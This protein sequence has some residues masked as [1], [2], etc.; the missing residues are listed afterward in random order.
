ML[1]KETIQD[2]KE[3]VSVELTLLNIKRKNYKLKHRTIV[4][5]RRMPIIV[6][7]N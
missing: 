5:V 1:P 3:M 6:Y 2:V 4:R 7:D